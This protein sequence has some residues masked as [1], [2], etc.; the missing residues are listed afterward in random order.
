MTF[1][2]RESTTRSYHILTLKAKMNSMPPS[3]SIGI[4]ALMYSGFKKI[5]ALMMVAGAGRPAAENADGAAVQALE[6]GQW[7]QD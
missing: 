1:S 5:I 7:G 3:F 4:N 2:L 6:E